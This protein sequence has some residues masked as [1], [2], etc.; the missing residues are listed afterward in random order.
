[1]DFLL[2]PLVVQTAGG[3]ILLAAFAQAILAVTASTRRR[4]LVGRQQDLALEALQV[5]VRTARREFEFRDSLASHGWEGA[6]KFVLARKIPEADG[7]HSF[8][9]EPHD[10]KPLPRFKPG[11]FLTF[12]LKIPGTGKTTIRCYSLSDSPGHAH[13]RVSIKKVPPPRDKPELPWG[14]SSCFFNDVL[15]EG[16]ILDVKAPAGGF[17]LDEQSPRP[18]VLIGGGIGITPVFSMLKAICESGSGREA[19]FFLGAIDSKNHPMKTQLEELAAKHPN[20]HLHICYSNPLEGDRQGIDYQHQ[21]WVGA[22]LFKEVLPSNNFEFYLCGPPPMMNSVTEG[23]A[24]WGVPEADVRFEAFGPATVKKKPAAEAVVAAT[25]AAAGP[26]AKVEF[27]RSGKTVD[28]DPKYESLLEMAEAN[29]I[30][31]DSG[32]RAGNCGTC[33]TALRKGNVKYLQQ[34]ASPPE[35]GSCLTCVSVPDGDVSIEA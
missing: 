24:E 5:Q 8:Y 3:L 12:Q 9:L 27:H 14:L 13:Y 17:H 16:D 20:V 31:M 15:Q 34:P 6:R 21:G 19:W 32:C 2:Q 23:L 35:S 18:V 22:P 33:V 25:A 4:L 26:A 7:V 10:G 28:W 1:M 29:G 11:Q 30:V